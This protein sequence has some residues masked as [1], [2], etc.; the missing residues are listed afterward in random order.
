MFL[1]I[2][3]TISNTRRSV[4]FDIKIP[5]FDQTKKEQKLKKQNQ[6]CALEPISSCLLRVSGQFRVSSG[7]ALETG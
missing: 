3:Q 6:G 4:S 2:F 1:I 5:R 7:K